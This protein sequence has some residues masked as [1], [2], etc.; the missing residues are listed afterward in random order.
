M[1]SLARGRVLTLIVAV[2]ILGLGGWT[3]TQK[4]RPQ[5]AAVSNV[6]TGLSAE[7]EA[8]RKEVAELKGN[9]A[10]S[11]REQNQSATN[12]SAKSTQIQ[13][14]PNVLN[15]KLNFVDPAIVINSREALLKVYG[16]NF[17]RGMQIKIGDSI[18]ELSANFQPNP[19]AGLAFAK[20]PSGFNPG[21]YNVS[22]I[23]PDKG[24][25]TLERGLTINPS[26]SSESQLLSAAEV[27]D[28]IK[29]AVV[30]IR[31]N[32]SCGSGV[33]ID[34]NQILTNAH[35]VS[36]TN[37]VNVLLADGSQVRAPVIFR[38]TNKDLALLAPE[39][40]SLYFATLADSSDE[41]LPQGSQVVALGFPLT[42]NDD[43]TLATEEGSITARRDGFLQTSARI[44][45]G[46]SGGPLVERKTGRVVG[47]NTLMIST[48]P[49]LNTTGLG[50][51]IPS[52]SVESWLLSLNR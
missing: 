40:N 37:I 7:I 14:G 25:F 12:I 1:F 33:V 10:S 45:A 41:A 19:Q 50:F 29:S 47:I 3:W 42:C 36:G 35:V 6:D 4:A 34:R 9:K 5:T 27:I 8:L 13:K 38:D 49:I 24:S 28:K 32:A 11:P 31:T 26:N 30:L 17:Q 15:P 39:R 18:L 44:H 48:S 46:N 22:V 16:E 21:V 2:A 20:L 52:N 51:A 43:R 23:N